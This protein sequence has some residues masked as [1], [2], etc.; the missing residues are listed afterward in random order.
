MR[1]SSTHV[2][3]QIVSL[4]WWRYARRVWSHANSALTPNSHLAPKLKIN[5]AHWKIHYILVEHD[6]APLT[7]T[8]VACVT[9]CSGHKSPDT[10]RHALDQGP[11]PSWHELQPTTG[12][13]HCLVQLRWKEGHPCLGS[14][15][16]LFPNMLNWVHVWTPIWPV[17]DLNTLLVQIGCRVTCCMG[18]GIVL[19]MH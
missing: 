9:A 4:S 11:H 3:W 17:H 1:K 6:I 16:T 5:T 18:R 19:D 13:Q 12:E 10:T 15:L 14:R 8:L 7:P 2:N